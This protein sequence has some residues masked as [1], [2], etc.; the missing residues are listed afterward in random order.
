MQLINQIGTFLIDIILVP[1]FALVLT[2][3]YIDLKNKPARDETIDAT[4]N[5]I[6]G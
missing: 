3:M 1:Y 4:V 2:Y 6:Q 5:G